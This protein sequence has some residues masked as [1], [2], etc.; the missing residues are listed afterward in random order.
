M[1]AVENDC[2]D[3][4]FSLLSEGCLRFECQTW[5][6]GAK[7]PTHPQLVKVRKNGGIWW[8]CPKCEA[9]YGAVR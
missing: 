8:C 2:E 5:E 6:P 7:K 1:F 3:Q 9:S 4:G